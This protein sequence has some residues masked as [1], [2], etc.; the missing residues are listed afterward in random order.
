MSRV[1]GKMLRVQAIFK[2][3]MLLNNIFNV[4]SIK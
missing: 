3:L 2:K 1:E 4:F